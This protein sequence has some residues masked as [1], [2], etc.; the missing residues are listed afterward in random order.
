MCNSEV[1]H[2]VNL[3]LRL[4]QW[5]LLTQILKW[6]KDVL[7]TGFFSLICALNLK[8]KFKQAAS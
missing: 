8:S 2:G 5:L 7:W 6:K 4:L 1:E 3:D